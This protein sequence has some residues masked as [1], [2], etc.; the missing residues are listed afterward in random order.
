MPSEQTL[1]LIRKWE[2]CKLIAYKDVA[3][4]WTIGYG[5]TEGVKMGD[6]CTKEQAEEWLYEEAEWFQKGVL[7]SCKVPPNSNQLT[8]LVSFTYNLGLGNLRQSTLLRKHNIGNFAGAANEFLKWNK[9]RH[10]VTKQLREVSGLTERRKDERR[11]YLTPE[12]ATP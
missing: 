8:A 5:H 1:A 2:G 6:T 10:P 11:I 4:V 3:G 12:G 9:A 7:G